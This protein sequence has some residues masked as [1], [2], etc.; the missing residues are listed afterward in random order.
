MVPSTFTKKL[1][2][3]AIVVA[4]IA[5]ISIALYYDQHPAGKKCGQEL[6]SCVDACFDHAGVPIGL[7][8]S[9]E[10]KGVNNTLSTCLTDCLISGTCAEDTDLFQAIPGESEI[11]L[12]FRDPNR[13][14][15]VFLDGEQIALVTG[16]SYIIQNLIPEAAY[17]VVVKETDSGAEEVDYLYTLSPEQDKVDHKV[18]TLINAQD[19]ET[20]TKE[21]DDIFYQS[22]LHV[23]VSKH[24]IKLTIRGLVPSNDDILQVYRDEQWIGTMKNRSFIDLQIQPGK[25]YDYSVRTA[26]EIPQKEIEQRRQYIHK[27]YLGTDNETLKTLDDLFGCSRSNYRLGKSHVETIEAIQLLRNENAS[28][29]ASNKYGP[30]YLRYITFIPWA[31]IENPLYWVPGVD[32]KYFNGN[33]RGFKATT[34]IE[35][36]HK[37]KTWAE[38]KADF[39]NKKVGS[40]VRVGPT[41]GYDKNK[42]KLWE[43]TADYHCMELTKKDLSKADRYTWSF[44]HGCGMPWPGWAGNLPPDIDYLYDAKVWKNGNWE[45]RGIHDEC[46]SH[47]V[48]IGREGNKNNEKRWATIHRWSSSKV[49]V[50]PIGI[51]GG[52]SSCT[53]K[54]RNSGKVPA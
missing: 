14:Y 3:V 43:D 38:V 33:N 37:Y 42:K 54:I 9:V 48:Y 16:T 22:S 17:E 26:K 32:T 11:I 45:V 21:L 27:M 40:S 19:S 2:I 24:Q 18:N 8:D 44:Y 47:E 52:L 23:H 51:G 6:K 10:P 12:Q 50:L 4:L 30:Y 36:K 15:V 34:T 20:P 28:V 13:S 49:F 5:V 29:Q 39:A 41:I 53:V 46:P 25:I 1:I 35:E 31:Y 7:N